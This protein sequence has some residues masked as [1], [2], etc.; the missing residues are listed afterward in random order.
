MHAALQRELKN[1]NGFD[2]VYVLQDLDEGSARRLR[3]LD[4][5]VGKR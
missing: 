2:H 4:E 5:V 1:E 3:E